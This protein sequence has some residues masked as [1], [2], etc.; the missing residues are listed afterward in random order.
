MLP[1]RLQHRLQQVLKLVGL[2]LGSV[3]VRCLG[4]WGVEGRGLGR[5]LP[6]ATAAPRHLSTVQA[7]PHASREGRGNVCGDRGTPLVQSRLRHGL[8]WESTVDPIALLTGLSVE[9]QKQR[10]SPG[11][12]IITQPL[13][14][15]SILPA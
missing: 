7:V 10:L 5:G 4:G 14:P 6:M 3:G 8:H 15:K 12:P 2:P 1:E 9:E 13:Q 11:T